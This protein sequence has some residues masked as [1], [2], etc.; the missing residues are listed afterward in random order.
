MDTVNLQNS[1]FT[2][3]IEHM[4]NGHCPIAI[5]WQWTLSNCNILAMDTVQLQYN[6]LRLAMY[7][8]YWTLSI[9]NTLQWAFT[10]T[11]WTFC[12]ILLKSVVTKAPYT[13]QHCDLYAPIGWPSLH[14]RRLTQ[15]LQVIY[16]SLLGK[17]P[18]YLS[19]LVTITAPTRSTRSS[20]YISLVIPK[21]N[22]YFG[23]PFL[24]FLCCQ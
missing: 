24:P 2:L 18:P 17:A 9:S 14:I 10:I 19:S 11:N 15:W 5:Y 8:V 7:Y 4:C 16:K 21:A 1:M 12:Y 23:S 6:M 3:T 22:T 13:S 20:R